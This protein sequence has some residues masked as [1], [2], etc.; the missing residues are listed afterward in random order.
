MLHF[1]R[2]ALLQA[3]H[4]TVRKGSQLPLHRNLKS[5]SSEQLSPQPNTYLQAEKSILQARRAVLRHEVSRITGL[6]GVPV[7]AQTL[8]SWGRFTLNVFQENF[9]HVN[10]DH[11]AEPLVKS[12]GYFEMLIQHK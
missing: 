8:L 6:Q 12:H 4:L 11:I 5:Q 3:L 9:C 1:P 7:G 2:A 10:T